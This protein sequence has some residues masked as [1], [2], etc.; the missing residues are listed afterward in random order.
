MLI[1]LGSGFQI[2]IVGPTKLGYCW[3]NTVSTSLGTSYSLLNIDLVLA[4]SNY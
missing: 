2:G 4:L 1:P 3:V